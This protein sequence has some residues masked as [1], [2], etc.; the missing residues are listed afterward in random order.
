MCQ[1]YLLP[2]ILGRINVLGGKIGICKVLKEGSGY[3]YGASGHK[4]GPL[5]LGEEKKEQ[6]QMRRK[7]KQY[8]RKEMT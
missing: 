3:C 2:Y 6:K 1:I 7:V 8:N 5:L 4:Q